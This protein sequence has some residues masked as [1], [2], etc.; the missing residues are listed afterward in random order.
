MKPEMFQDARATVNHQASLSTNMK[1][2]KYFTVNPSANYKETWYFDYLTKQYNPE[3]AE[4]ATDT[5]NGFKA[6]REYSSGISLSTNVYGTF[7]I[8]RGRLKAIRHTI[9]PSISYSYRPDFSFY[10]KTVYNP[11]T[12]ETEEYSPYKNGIYGTPGRGISN[13]IGIS[14]NNTLEAKVMSKD[15][16]KTEAKK[17]NLLNNLNFSTSYNIAADTMRWSPVSMST[18]A[19]LFKNKMRININASLDPYAINAN[20][21]RIDTYNIMNGGSLFRLTRA[22]VTMNY[23]LSNKTFSGNETSGN[24]TQNENARAARNERNM[25]GSNLNNSGNSNDSDK[26]KKKV[27]KLYHAKMPWNLSL[28]YSLQYSNSRREDEISTNSLMFNGEI[29]LSPKWNVGINSGYDF[30]RKGITYTQLHFQRDLDS[31]KM[32][33]NWVP[34]GSR[35]TYYFFIGVKSSVLSELKYDKRKLPDKR[36][37]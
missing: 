22:G 17:I 26:S 9:R 25:M 30:K 3:E 29:E 35:T 16:T 20:G 28:S 5:L 15:S 7:K 19:Q 37:F 1:L 21:N 33:F 11:D 24:D 12:Q 23:N 27:T 8:K 4:I 10:D 31:W 36:L 2:F 14:L 18:G 32:S 34:F 13:S 6:L